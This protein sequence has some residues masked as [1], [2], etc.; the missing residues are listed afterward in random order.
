LDQFDFPKD[1]R[2]F[3]ETYRNHF[4]ITRLRSGAVYVGEFANKRR[5][6][7][8]LCIFPDR[9]YY[10]GQWVN[11]KSEGEGYLINAD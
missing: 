10:F 6:G 2:D 4:K 1:I 9:S 11:D 8:G 7:R 5:H 3:L